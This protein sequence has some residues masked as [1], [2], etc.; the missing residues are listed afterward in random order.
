MNRFPLFCKL[1]MVAPLL[2]AI[3]SF[4]QPT[5]LKAFIPKGYEILDTTTGDLNRDAWPDMVMVLRKKGEDSTSDVVEHPEK[6]PLLVLLG[7]PDHSYKLA[8]RNDNVVYCVDCGGMMGDPFQGVTIKQGYFSVEHYGGSAWRWTRIITFKY[9]PEDKN[10]YLYKDGGDSFH[11][12]MPDSV[13]TKVRTVKDF[14]K[15]PL[16]KYDIYKRD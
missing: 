2:I 8:A 6:R 13:T 15:V 1:W 14:G 16:V 3:V 11:A 10:W 9:A 7:Q 5:S 4:Q 12:S